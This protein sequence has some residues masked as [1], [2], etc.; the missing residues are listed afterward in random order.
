MSAL[1]PTPTD[2]LGRLL[3]AIAARKDDG[4]R[5]HCLDLRPRAPDRLGEVC[6]LL[7]LS[8]RDCALAPAQPQAPDDL[9]R[10]LLKPMRGAAT[11]SWLN[12]ALFDEFVAR[13]DALAGAAPRWRRLSRDIHAPLRPALGAVWDAFVADA[14]DEGAWLILCTWEGAADPFATPA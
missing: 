12:G 10:W 11:Q 13:L 7:R 4:S 6:A 1:S 2:R 3:D 9:R 14:G 5:F 8:P